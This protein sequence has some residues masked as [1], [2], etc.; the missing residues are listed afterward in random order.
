MPTNGE[1]TPLRFRVYRPTPDTTGLTD[2]QLLV[3]S[4][5]L[6]AAKLACLSHYEPGDYVLDVD[7]LEQMVPAR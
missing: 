5:T 4:D 1:N 3:S 7:T 2:A 6:D